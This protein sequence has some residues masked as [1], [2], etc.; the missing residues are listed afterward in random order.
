M[1][2]KILP[3]QLSSCRRIVNRL[4]LHHAQSIILLRSIQMSN[5]IKI[6]QTINTVREIRAMRHPR[7]TTAI[8][9]DRV[10]RRLPR[11]V[12]SAGSLEAPLTDVRTVD[13]YD[14]KVCY[15]LPRP[16]NRLP[17]RRYLSLLCIA[18]SK[19][20][21]VRKN[22]C[23]TEPSSLSSQLWHNNYRRTNTFSLVNYVAK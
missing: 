17:S 20:K 5:N 23:I 19:L 11:Y 1:N 14:S 3:A 18:P 22:S 9:F 6:P 16:F 2:V 4:V 8:K 7:F 10:R 13:I 15:S 21:N 12:T